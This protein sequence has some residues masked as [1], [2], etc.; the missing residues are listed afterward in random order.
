MK[1]LTNIIRFDFFFL[2][3]MIY[4]VSCKKYADPQDDVKE[5]YA[6]AVRFKEFEEA[7]RPLSSSLRSNVAM[8]NRSATSINANTAQEG[9]MYYW[10]FNQ[11]SLQP[12]MFSSTGTSITYN[13]GTVPSGFGTGWSFESYA[14][15]QA[16]SI[17]G[18]SEITVKLPLSGVT[19][20][21]ALGFDIG[22]SGTGAKNFTLSYSQDGQ[23]FTVLS[24]DNQFTNTN[25][26]QAKNS[27]I[28][29]LTSLSLDYT[30]DLYIRLIPT[31][32]SRGTAGEYR[33]S[34]GVLKMD[35]LR[36]MGLTGA[37]TRQ[38]AN[39]QQLH[40]HVFDAA[41]NAL[42]LSGVYDFAANELA[43]FS[44][45]LPAGEYIASYVSNASNA[46]LSIPAAA[47]KASYYIAN[48]FSNHQA[49]I[50]GVLDTFT[51]AQDIEREITLS[52]YCSQV[53]FEFTDAVDLAAVTKIVI[54]RQ[55]DPEYYAPF[56]LSLVNPVLDQSEIV[57]E[58]N[59]AANGKSIFFNQ[60]IG[61]VTS[62]LALSYT[63][64]AFNASDVLL[65]SFQIGS[66]A[67][68]NVQ[69]FFRG[70]L[71]PTG[72]VVSNFT[73]SFNENWS[74]EQIISF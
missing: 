28:F 35:N 1:K 2:S 19:S 59:F 44:L 36:L 60:F 14:A 62:P 32:G 13:Q 38:D 54:S 65:R 50:F 11:G 30:Q 49:E 5:S 21:T 37:G 61:Q 24:D 63:V 9:Y 42:V 53:K 67:R 22:S 6:V 70:A 74:G 46:A 39:I 66:A 69:L 64:E 55:H 73:I 20:V 26:A 34:T 33:E 48:N 57:I 18:A 72:E 58:P 41:S 47:T 25:T 45:N 7:T 71:L 17:T 68:N 10:S 51:V 8:N 40:Y 15:G 27:F 56:N 43:D 52:R 16:L 3:I 4:A 12:D 31:A 29:Q 23:R